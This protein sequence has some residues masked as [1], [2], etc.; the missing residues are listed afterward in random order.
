LFTLGETSSVELML[1]GVVLDAPLRSIAPVL[2]LQMS[3]WDG[4]ECVTQVEVATAPRLTAALRGY[5]EPGTYCAIV[6]DPGSLTEV[7]G[8][9]LRIVA[10][11]LLR[12][13]GEP[14]S[15]TFASTITPA[16]TNVRTVRASTAGT[17]A[18]TLRSLSASG[19]AGLALG[20]PSAD[21]SRCNFAQIVRVLPGDAPQITARVDAGDFCVGIFDVGNIT[22]NESF[23]MTIAHP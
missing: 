10:P 17:I 12:A 3:R 1:A 4:T 13:T 5:F 2:R 14:G 21:F 9:S 20:I 6:S 15:D 8:V 18:V 7:A 11:A 22:K 23:S 16:G 19:E